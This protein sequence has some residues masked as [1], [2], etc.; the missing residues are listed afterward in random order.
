MTKIV[1]Y[2]RFIKADRWKKM[3]KCIFMN[4]G[5]YFNATY[6][7]RYHFLILTRRPNFHSRIC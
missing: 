4:I 2:V 1:I 3:I 5:I 6:I 7:T